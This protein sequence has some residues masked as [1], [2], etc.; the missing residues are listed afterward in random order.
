MADAGSVVADGIAVDDERELVGAIA[1]P[2]GDVGRGVSPRLGAPLP[3]YL[4]AAALA[5]L[6]R[7]VGHGRSKVID[8][9]ADDG[10]AARARL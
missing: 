1:A 3:A 2:V 9:E 5:D 10:I 6:E 7:V 4:Y 8:P